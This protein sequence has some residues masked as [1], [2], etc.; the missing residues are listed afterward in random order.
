MIKT[1]LKLTIKALES[2]SK[3]TTEESNGILVYFSNVDL[4]ELT[5]VKNCSFFFIGI[6]GHVFL[7][8]E[9]VN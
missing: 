7:S 4:R 9:L 5:M 2:C 3:Y 6:I 1:F 8:G